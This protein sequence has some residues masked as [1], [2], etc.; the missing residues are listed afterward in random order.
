[1][2]LTEHGSW[3]ELNARALAH[4]LS[5]FRRLAGPRHALMVVV[6]SNAYGHGMVEIARL[7]AGNGADWLGVFSIFEALALRAAGLELPVLVFGPTPQSF[8]SKA[9]EQ[10]IR[11]TIGATEALPR[12]LESDVRGLKVHL[13]LETGTN[14]QGFYERELD[15]IARLAAIPGLEIEGAYTHYADIEDTTDHHYA[16]EQLARFT[17][18]LALLSGIGIEPP[19]KHTACSAAALLFPD[20][21]HSLMRVGISAYG[22]WP[23]KETRLSA[24]QLGLTDITLLPVMSWKTR[25]A[26]V[27]D[28]AVGQYVSYGR[29]W[30]STR[31]TR[32]AVLPIGYANGYDRRLSN[33]AYVLIGGQRASILGRICM[34]MCMAD[35]TDIPG[36]K[37]GDEVV[38][39]G[40][41]GEEMLSAE[42]LANWIGTINYEVVTR[43]EPIGPRLVV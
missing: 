4:N 24:G 1:M 32:L 34:N 21:R 42:T 15:A 27:K 14:R 39:L 29:N 10:G 16:S 13:K 17:N 40:R 5:M 9:A 12:L 23:S 11:L 37:A 2:E 3:I 35:V 28:L 30:R 26:Q 8:Y 7:A 36:A 41:Q 6:K 19:V 22:L 25:I 31:P 18:W 20:T 43:A 38:L 33:T